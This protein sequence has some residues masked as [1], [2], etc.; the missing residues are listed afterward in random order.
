MDSEIKND[1]LSKRT[2]YLLWSIKHMKSMSF[3]C[4]C[5]CG[6]VDFNHDVPEF[7]FHFIANKHPESKR[8]SGSSFWSFVSSILSQKCLI[9]VQIQR[10]LTHLL[11][12]REHQTEVHSIIQ[13]VSVIWCNWESEKKGM[14]VALL[15]LFLWQ[16]NATYT[17]LPILSDRPNLVGF[18]P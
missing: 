13:F 5:L 10:R 9:Y 2:L 18:R 11:V 16:P 8:E 17:G 1:D 15:I 12:E 3:V 14:E 4:N 7:Y 6:I